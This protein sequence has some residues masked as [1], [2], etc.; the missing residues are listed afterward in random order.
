MVAERASP[1]CKC[2]Y[3]HTEKRGCRVNLKE[4]SVCIIDIFCIQLRNYDHNFHLK[5]TTQFCGYITVL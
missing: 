5:D 4:N 3:T 1:F 2:E